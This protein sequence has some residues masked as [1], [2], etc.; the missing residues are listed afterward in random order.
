MAIEHVLC[1]EN[2]KHIHT[3]S[4]KCA[5]DSIYWN[6]NAGIQLNW[7]VSRHECQ[8]PSNK[9]IWCENDRMHKSVNIGDNSIRIEYHSGYFE[10]TV[11]L[12]HENPIIK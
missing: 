11:Q 12:V 10:C 5:F 2:V 4:V 3:V 1:I 8:N 9:I 6:S 7:F